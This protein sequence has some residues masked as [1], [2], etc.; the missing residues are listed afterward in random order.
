MASI[1]T[2][3][4][5]TEA[6]T[7]CAKD[8][9]KLDKVTSDIEDFFS[10]L[11]SMT[12]LK[13]VLWSSTFS[14]GERKGVIGDLASKRGYDSLT[15]NFLDLVLELDKFK[16]LLNSEQTFIQKLRKASG[17]LK[18]EIITAS[19]SSESDLSRIKAKLT[20][21]M[22]Q[23]VEVSSKVDPE[24]IGGIIAKVEDRVFDGSIKT[25]LEKIRGVLSQS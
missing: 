12:E 18:A 7:Q 14:I 4:D 24:I 3:R 17:K 20:E 21:V 19:P 15:S 16:F 2:L 8:E 1:A 9:G 10:L 6:L 13:N 23:E 22:G 25:Q 5:L 11:S